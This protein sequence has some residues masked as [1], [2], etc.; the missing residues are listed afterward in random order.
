MEYHDRHVYQQVLKGQKAE[1]R[2]VKK[3]GYGAYGQTFL[4]K[5]IRLTQT[6]DLPRVALKEG[7][8]VAIKLPP[9]LD[10][11]SYSVNERRQFLSKVNEC[12][13][14]EYSMAPRLARIR[15]AAHLIDI[16]VDP[17]PLGDIPDISLFIVYEYIT[18]VSLERW[19]QNQTNQVI[20]D[21]FFNLAKAITTAV[22]DIHQVGI[23]HGDLWPQNIMIRGDEEVVIVDFG[24]A[25]RR[26][27]IE[28]AANAHKTHPYLAPE[29]FLSIASDIY[30]LGGTLYFL[31]TGA[32]PP[33]V[34]GDRDQVKAEVVRGL[35]THNLSLYQTADGIADIIARC[36]RPLFSK[37]V[38]N[39]TEVLY[40]INL[41]DRKI[42]PSPA[43]IASLLEDVQDGLN[44][45]DLNDPFNASVTELSL[46]SFKQTIT[47]LVD[48]IHDVGGG[49]DELVRKYSS[50]LALV[51][52]DDQYLAVSIPSFWYE[53]NM[54][55]RG[56]ALELNKKM[57]RQGTT[58]R[59]VFIVTHEE[60]N[61]TQTI[62]VLKAHADLMDTVAEITLSIGI[63][64][65]RKDLCE[66]GAFTGILAV[67]RSIRSDGFGRFPH[68]EVWIE[69]T[70]GR[71]LIP[72][73]DEG[74]QRVTDLHWRP[75][76][77]S[78]K[79]IQD[80]YSNDYLNPALEIRQFLNAG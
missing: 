29:R 62:E 56:R 46:V 68:G 20:A 54:G 24:E 53:D 41:F 32:Q 40:D 59:R 27:Q 49:H 33:K 69:R 2:V 15:S 28:Q 30:S 51:Q 35:R 17:V 80:I 18:G 11:K 6:P 45:I 5:V 73:F 76:D 23:V 4:G 72:V 78:Y 26:N 19:R 31:A 57:I 65:V 10:D 8:D 13:R 63:Q 55:V 58:L 71:F 34:N 64:T 43:H 38:Q 44:K 67:E 61:N 3:I 66:G 60:L 48:D 37:R 79:K 75:I 21:K 47:Q 22:G 42:A 14:N 50:F 12:F 1:Y 9:V 70:R 39:A 77:R 7:M 52:P 16:G 25:Y 74:F 36:L